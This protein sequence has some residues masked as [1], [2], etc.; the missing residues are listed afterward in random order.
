MDAL[1]EQ[2]GQ[3]HQL[4]LK[5]IAQLMD[6]PNIRSGDAKTF[7]KFALKVRGLVGML[8]QLGVIGQTELMCGSHVSRILT[9]M[10]HHLRADFKRYINPLKTPIPT[11]W[12]LSEWLEYEVRVQEDSYQVSNSASRAQPPIKREQVR[13]YG[14]KGTFVLHG[15]QH[16]LSQCTNFKILT[17]EQV[18]KWIRSNRRELALGSHS[19][20]TAALKKKYYHL[21]DLPIPDVEHAQPLLLIGSDHPHLILPTEPVICGPPDGP[22]AVKTLMGWTLQGPSKFLKH[23]LPSAQCLLTSTF[24]PQDSLFAHVERLW[25]LDV[26]PYRSEKVVTRSREDSEALK[27]L[28]D[29]TVR[30]E[31]DGVLRYATPL[32]WRK[33]LPELTAPKEAVLPHLRSTEKRLINDPSKTAAYKEEISKLLSSGYVKKLTPDEVDSSPGW[34]IPHHMV[35]HNAKNRV[36]FNCSYKY[37]GLSLNEHLRPGPTLSSSLLGVL[38]RF[39]ENAVAI[40]SDVKGMFHQVRLLPEDQPYLRFLWR[41]TNAEPPDIYQWLVLPF[42]T[43]SSPCCAT[44][45]LQTHVTA[46]S[47]PN[48]DVRSA[49]ERCFYVDNWLQSL[50]S[51]EEA[52]ML[53]NKLRSLLAN[54]GFELRQ[55]A[56][57]HPEVISH[58]PIECTSDST[59][60]WLTQNSHDPQEL[61]L[62][63]C[64]TAGPIH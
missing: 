8:E 13:D 48:D 9:K 38:L 60:L 5:R 63:L 37:K 27:T 19:Y 3:P 56:S 22:A 61:A 39:R 31:I 1:N 16:F 53:A 34:Y 26:L 41:N 49:V 17:K 11:L 57:S 18:D 15:V 59:K 36:V 20:P 42:G 62:G 40:S 45:A 25:Q 12:H 32:L 23:S 58:L 54:G 14:N 7:R 52:K 30:V 6:E 4:A 33:D 55:W 35:T 2:Y 50:H 24:I 29:K 44:F 46:H 51:V 28:E 21:Q 47:Q 64:G 10:P 43:V